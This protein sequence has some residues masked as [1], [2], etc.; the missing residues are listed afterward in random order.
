MELSR[1]MMG[2]SCRPSPRPWANCDRTQNTCA[3]PRDALEVR[4]R[5]LVDV[6]DREAGAGDPAGIAVDLLPRVEDAGE[7][8]VE[9]GVHDYAPAALDAHAHDLDELPVRVVAQLERVETFEVMTAEMGDLARTGDAEH[10]VARSGLDELGERTEVVELSSARPRRQEQRRA[11][12]ERAFAP[13]RVERVVVARG[14]EQ[15]AAV[16]DAGQPVPRELGVHRA[17]TRLRVLAC[18]A[19]RERGRHRERAD[20]AHLTREASVLV[21]HKGAARRIGGPFNSRP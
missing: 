11:H 6:D 18:D 8:V 7:G 12:V 21:A 10:V 20:T 17:H 2:R 4:L 1:E 13:H 9:H 3:E 16:D 15:A 19:Q 5:R 14:H